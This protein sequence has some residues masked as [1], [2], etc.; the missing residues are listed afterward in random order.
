MACTLIIAEIG[1]NHVGDMGIAKKLIAQAANAGAD[2]VKFQSYTPGIFRKT[3]PEYGWFK[4]VSLSDSAHFQLKRWAEAKG[5][6]F[7]SSP[8]SVERARFLCEQLALREIKIASGVLMQFKLLDY[9]N[10]SDI[11]TAF[12]STGLSTIKEIGEALKHLKRIPD[13]YLLH[14]VTQYPCKPE[15][16]NLRAIAA[17]KKE[18]GLPVGYSDHTIGIDACVTAAAVGACVIEKHFTF[19]K[20]S[21]E[22]TDHALSATAAD[23]R[24]MVSRIRAQ[25]ELLGNGVK[26]PSKGEKQV[27]RFVRD[28]FLKP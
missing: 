8:F 23:L 4:K 26:K 25:E 1:E 7:L 9:L 18:F 19:D 3:D 10:S 5:V 13:I 22:G 12:V 17:L 2:Y 14:C 16:A 6:K 21:R 28:R 15:E 20:K 11:R 24:E 27:L